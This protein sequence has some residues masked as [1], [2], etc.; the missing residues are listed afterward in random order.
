MVGQDA[1]PTRTVPLASFVAAPRFHSGGGYFAPNE[2]PAVLLENERVLNPAETRAYNAGQCTATVPSANTQPSI[3]VA[4]N[5]HN[6]GGGQVKESRQRQT[7]M[8]GASMV[9]DLFLQGWENNT[10]NVRNVLAQGA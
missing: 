9:I 1:N 6:E 7:R 8:D 10:G 4:V 2:Y 3:T 5:I